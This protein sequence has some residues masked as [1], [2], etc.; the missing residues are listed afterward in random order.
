MIQSLII[1]KNSSTT[2]GKPEWD[3]RRRNK[4]MMQCIFWG[5]EEFLVFSVQAVWT[6]FLADEWMQWGRNELVVFKSKRG[7]RK[8]ERR[9]EQMRYL[10]WLKEGRGAFLIWLERRWYREGRG[11]RLWAS[12]LHP[13]WEA[14]AW[15]SWPLVHTC[16][17]GSPCCLHIWSPPAAQR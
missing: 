2:N 7:E 4:K 14:C 16:R 6:W 1:Y 17:L 10:T 11:R 13:W 3:K 8:R 15:E 9:K 5:A 12:S